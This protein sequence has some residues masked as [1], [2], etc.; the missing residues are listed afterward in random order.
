M[1]QRIDCLDRYPKPKKANPL[2]SS[3][4]RLKY[5]CYLRLNMCVQFH[6]GIFVFFLF[7]TA[8]QLVIFKSARE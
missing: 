3:V 7:K 4:V 2:P 8:R 1:L 5:D 6:A